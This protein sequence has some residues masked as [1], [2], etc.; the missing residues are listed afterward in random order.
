MSRPTNPKAVTT[1][2][3]IILMTMLASSAP[4]VLAQSASPL[5]PSPSPASPSPT[6]V[7]HDGGSPALSSAPTDE[8]AFPWP[9]LTRPY[10]VRLPAALQPRGRPD[11]STTKHGIRVALWLS[12]P[13]AMPGEW[14]QAVVRTT[15]TGDTPAWFLPYPCLRSGTVVS[16]DPRSGIPPGIEQQGNAAELKRKAV[17]RGPYLWANFRDRKD[18]LRWVTSGAEA[19]LGRAYV[20][21]PATSQPRRLGSGA[22]VTERFAW[23]PASSF[24]E[25]VWFQPLWPGTAPV[26]VSWPFLG[27]GSKPAADVQDLWAR[28][29]RISATATLELGGD[30]PGTPSIPELVDNALAD[31]RFRAWVDEDPTRESWSGISWSSAAGPIYP[32]NLLS[33]GLQDPP[34]NGLLWLA[35]GR[36]Q[37]QRGV[38]TLDPWTGE[39]LRVHCVGP[40]LGRPCE[41]S[42]AL[43][44]PGQ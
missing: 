15:N 40:S 1:G 28:V 39:V 27:R 4:G 19:G 44:E 32:H 24:D 34:P 5:S 31:P 20:E 42:T 3:L 43:D 23:Y 35:L 16:I 38:V 18:V 12:T 7:V 21:C 36:H 6:A 14:V 33:I 17:R 22:S 29:K 25:D 41:G 37:V 8:P 26:T 9:V 10:D 30:G 13:T 2:I 11:A